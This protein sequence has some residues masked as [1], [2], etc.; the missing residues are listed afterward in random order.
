MTA[1]TIER[2]ESF[3]FFT[4]PEE[5]I[6]RFLLGQEVVFSV[7]CARS[8]VVTMSPAFSVCM[9]GAFASCLF[10]LCLGAMNAAACEREEAAE[11]KASAVSCTE[12]AGLQILSRQ[13][14][15]AQLEAAPLPSRRTKSVER[16]QGAVPN[17]EAQAMAKISG[18]ALPGIIEHLLLRP[19]PDGRHEHEH[20]SIAISYPSIGRSDV[21]QDI[22]QWVTEI[23]DT[24]EQNI[25]EGIF[26]S[27]AESG[28][29]AFSSSDSVE[30][31]ADYSVSRPSAKA[32]SITFE[33]WNHIGGP[34]A[35]L[36]V[37]TLNYSLI[38]GQRL[39]LADIFGKPDE[40]LKLM[41]NWARET[42]S[43]RYGAGRTKMLFHG[44]EPLI[45]NFS[46]LTLTP[47]GVSIH[48][49]PYQVAT[50]EMGVQTVD[51]PLEALAAAQPLMV[52]WGK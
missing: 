37:V 18:S 50:W 48:F 15:L 33:L 30:L 52:F 13:L 9:G 12:Y 31:Q 40:A 27:I 42:L 23:A 8:S 17:E 4:V 10:C 20:M 44:T 35:N 5:L 26:T 19:L 41:S 24:F 6:Q 25:E 28:P 34:H 47:E 38:N 29:F 16:T 43:K 46:S 7:L 11:R 22:R 39:Q 51:M 2:I 21:D 1:E 36:D 49:Q 14:A 32:L 3:L 45:E